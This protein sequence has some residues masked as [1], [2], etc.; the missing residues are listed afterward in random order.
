MCTTSFYSR[1]RVYMRPLLLLIYLLLLIF[2]VPWLI[3]NSVKDGFNTKDQLV[4]ISGLFVIL[5]L[6]ISFWHISQHIGTSS[7]CN[8]LSKSD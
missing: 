6:P 4:L 8:T 5:A 3:V 7:L 2:V 1:W